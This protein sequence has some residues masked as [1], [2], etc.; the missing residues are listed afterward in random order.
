MIPHVCSVSHKPPHSYGDCLRA[1]IASVL[2]IENINHV[3]HFYHDGCDSEVADQRMKEFLI[4]R[5]LMPYHMVFH[6]DATIEKIFTH[7]GAINP[8]VYYLLFGRDHVVV[9]RG[10]KMVHDTAWYKEPLQNPE[11]HW[12]VTTFVPLSVTN[13]K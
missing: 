11:G 7:M 6:P 3:P 4:S 12:V 8:N 13:W 5:G 1:S 9:C 10:D 2:D